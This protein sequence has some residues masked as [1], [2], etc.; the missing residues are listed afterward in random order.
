MVIPSRSRGSGRLRARQVE[1]ILSGDD[2]RDHV[3]AFLAAMVQDLRDVSRTEVPSSVA[4][5]HLLKMRLATEMGE[6]GPEPLRDAEERELLPPQSLERRRSRITAVGIAAAMVVMVG[7]AATLTGPPENAG[8]RAGDVRS[9]VPPRLSKDGPGRFDRFVTN[10]ARR[11]ASTRGPSQPPV[12]S[13]GTA[14]GASSEQPA[15]AGAID[16]QGPAQRSGDEPAGGGGSGG[17]D[18]GSADEPGSGG[19]SGSVGNVGGRET[20]GDA[21][22]G[23]KSNA[24]GNGRGKGEGKSR[25][26]R[27]QAS[28]HKEKGSSKRP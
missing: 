24:H 22:Q 13:T 8:T 20:G 9:G 21:D 19:G 11:A 17:A 10:E 7:V 6:G 5:R 4:A 15:S 25:G 2:P 18:T 3:S 23:P 1:R 28:G 27:A 12:G 16:S 14:G 26:D